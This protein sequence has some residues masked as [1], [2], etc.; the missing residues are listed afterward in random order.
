MLHIYI[1]IYIYI[2][3]ISRLRLKKDPLL[4]YCA[5]IYVFYLLVYADD[6]NILGGSLHTIRK[7]K[8]EAVLVARKGIGLEVNSGKSKY[9]VI[10]RD[11]NSG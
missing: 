2:Y 6:F 8:K 4:F 11:Q 1:Y 3:D 5:G 9:V 10:S 7:K